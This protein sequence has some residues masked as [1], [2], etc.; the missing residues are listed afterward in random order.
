MLS[1]PRCSPAYQA[2]S[3]VQSDAIG[4]AANATPA[5]LFTVSYSADSA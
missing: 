2:M 5:A 1:E 4:Y 3:A